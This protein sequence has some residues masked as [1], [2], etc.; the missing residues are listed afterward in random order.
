MSRTP[1]REAL[2]RLEAVGLVETAANRYTRVCNASAQEHERAVEV[3]RLLF[4]G[5]GD[6]GAATRLP[7]DLCRRA[8]GLVE[9]LTAHDLDA[10]RALLDVRGRCLAT[11][12]NSLISDIERAV[13]VRAQFHA[14]ASDARIDWEREIELARELACEAS[15]PE[16][17]RSDAV[18]LGAGVGARPA[19]P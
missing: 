6:R 14:G 7:P 17:G 5:A 15:V 10:Y 16:W 9:R 19:S 12:G 11:L 3:L 8:R 4:R 2:A 13:R 1:V 18:G